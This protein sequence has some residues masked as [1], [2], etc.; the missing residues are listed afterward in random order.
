MSA[1]GSSAAAVEEEGKEAPSPSSA[2]EPLG[3]AA[4]VREDRWTKG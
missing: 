1:A 4:Q 3:P 2:T